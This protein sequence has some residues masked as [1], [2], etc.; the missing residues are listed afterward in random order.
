MEDGIKTALSN[1]CSS[2][3]RFLLRT[4][5]SVNEEQFIFLPLVGLVQIR[6]GAD[7]FV[8]A[9]LLSLQLGISAL[10]TRSMSH[11][12]FAILQIVGCDD[13]YTGF[14]VYSFIWKYLL[15]F[16]CTRYGS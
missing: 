5:F 3:C 9:Q 15:S 11:L 10:W 12:S 16:C 1:I 13:R 14:F 2:C 7:K 8:C 4:Y 6:R